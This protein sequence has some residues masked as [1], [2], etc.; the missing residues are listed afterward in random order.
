LTGRW[1]LVGL[2][3]LA[4]AGCTNFQDR[5]HDPSKVEGP[6]LGDLGRRLVV[7]T[8]GMAKAGN[9]SELSVQFVEAF[10][11]E[12]EGSDLFDE[13]VTASGEPAP[14]GSGG[15]THLD[16]TLVSEDH[17]ILHDFWRQRDGYYERYDL[18]TRLT[19]RK[20]T[21]VL[22][23]DVSGI[24]YDDRFDCGPLAAFGIGWFG[25][26]DRTPESLSDDKV[27]DIRAAARRDAVQKI[28]R[29]LRNASSEQARGALKELKPIHLP[30]GVGPLP[31][32]VLGFD[33]DPAARHRRG[34]ALAR[35]T[36]GA[37]QRLGPDFA[38]VSQDEVENELGVDP[39]S[40]PRSF[41]KIRTEELDRLVPRLGA[42]LYLVGRVSADGNRVEA[43]AWFKN[44]RLQDVGEPA[45]AVCE[46]PGALSLVAV[47]LARKL[48]DTV[49]KHP[50]DAVPKKDEPETDE[51][52]SRPK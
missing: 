52:P 8:D 28:A 50:P 25:N 2:A 29:A 43:I 11:A 21:I 14:V 19:D 4:L 13:V 30:A 35:A 32:A 22:E 10:K 33:D 27:E 24:G 36:A 12:L 49:E 20:G 17:G 44:T 34:V 9:E 48:G 15:P 46:G 3:A 31:V 47:E 42:R 26:R 16:V 40:R 37:L 5:I 41:E 45:R 51:V 1:T 39:T 18:T 6:A 38:V 23:G 7:V